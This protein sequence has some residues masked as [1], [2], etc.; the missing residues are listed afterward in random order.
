MININDIKVGTTIKLEGDPYAVTEFQHVKPGKGSAFVR[1][2]LK[3]VRTGRVIPRTFNAGITVPRAYLD[4]K[5]MQFLYQDG[6]DYYFMDN[7]TYEQM[8][9]TAENLGEKIKYLQENMD[10]YVVF[11]EGQIIGVDF[12]AQVE[13]EVVE[14]EASIKGNTASGGTKPAKTNTGA[15]VKV[16]FFINEGDRIRVNT[17]TN[18][19]IERL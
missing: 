2:T 12:P 3:N 7:E 13:L 6:E 16:P 17:E 10:L 19:Y 18:E 8:A 14:T 1:T 4:R 5:M 9:L 11:F 15:V